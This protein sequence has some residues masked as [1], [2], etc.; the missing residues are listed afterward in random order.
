V[1]LDEG[2]CLSCALGSPDDGDSVGEQRVRHPLEGEA[3]VVCYDNAEWIHASEYD[4]FFGLREKRTG[5]NP[6][7]TVDLASCPGLSKGSLCL[8]L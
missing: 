7:Q 3:V 8:P 4:P 2:Y 6:R 5:H 1:F